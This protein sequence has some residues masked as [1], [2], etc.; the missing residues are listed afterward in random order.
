MSAG[1]RLVRAAGT[2]PG[3]T[4]SSRSSARGD[5]PTIVRYEPVAPAAVSATTRQRG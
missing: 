4:A 3:A 2:T 5:P 1:T